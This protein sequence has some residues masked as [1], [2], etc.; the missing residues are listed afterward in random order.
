MQF[1]NFIEELA[2]VNGRSIWFVV[3][4][5][6]AS[7]LSY[8]LNES[9]ITKKPFFVRAQDVTW[10]KVS[11]SFNTMQAPSGPTNL[12]DREHTVIWYMDKAQVESDKR[13]LKHDHF[14]FGF[15]K[16]QDSSSR[17]NTHNLRSCIFDCPFL[18]NKTLDGDKQVVNN[19]EKPAAYTEYFV[20]LLNL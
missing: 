14:P 20:S 19:A 4:T 9:P 5:C 1:E 13:T 10:R 11:Q 2:K 6:P 12:A 16:N 17:V 7:R 18:E 3:I 8:W 15:M